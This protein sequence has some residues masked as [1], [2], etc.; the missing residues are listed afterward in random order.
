MAMCHLPSSSN[1][2]NI[3]RI[4]YKRWQ[5]AHEENSPVATAAKTGVRVYAKENSTFQVFFFS[6]LPVFDLKKNKIQDLITD[7]N[8][9]IAK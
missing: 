1:Y 9:N 5:I 6:K 3:L 2:I 7:D 4:S 8:K